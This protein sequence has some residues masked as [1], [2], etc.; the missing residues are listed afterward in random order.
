MNFGLGLCRSAHTLI[1]GTMFLCGDSLHWQN[2]NIYKNWRWSASLNIKYPIQIKFFIEH[3]EHSHLIVMQISFVFN[4][5]TPEDF[6]ILLC[7]N[8]FACLSAHGP[9]TCSTHWGC[10]APSELE[11]QMITSCHMG[12]GHHTRVLWE[13]SVPLSLQRH[14]QSQLSINAF[15]IW[16]QQIHAPLLEPYIPRATPGDKN[17]KHSD[18]KKKPKKLRVHI[19][20]YLH[21]T[22]NF[23]K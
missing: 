23:L 16:Y 2:Q 18:S 17:S 1:F 12:A 11:L 21:F 3:T 15:V 6:L 7:I 20:G 14:P 13:Q 9:C 4:K 5:W 19:S 10:E 8:I 22:V